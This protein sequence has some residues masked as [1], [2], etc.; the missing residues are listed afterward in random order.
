MPGS[1]EIAKKEERRNAKHA[2]EC[3]YT[4]ALARFDRILG[5]APTDRCMAFDVRDDPV[6]RM[7]REV[8]I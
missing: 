5:F 3:R 7:P 8:G 1:G 2:P 6:S 4:R